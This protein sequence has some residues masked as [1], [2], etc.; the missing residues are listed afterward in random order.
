MITVVAAAA[1]VGAVWV[2]LAFLGL[3]LFFAL[4]PLAGA[5]GAAAVTAF[6]ALIVVL[7]GCLIAQH[8]IDQARQNSLVNNLISS[9]ALGAAAGFLGKRPLLSL[10]LGG[11]LAAL[12][13]TASRP[14]K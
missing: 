9:G 4:A 5:A 14:R 2:L 13:F 8:K 1:L 6:A 12:F 10:G 11:A 7:I 3:A